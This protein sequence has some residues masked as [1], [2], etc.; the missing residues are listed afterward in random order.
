MG[1]S[2]IVLYILAG[3]IGVI[4]SFEWGFNVR[5]IISA[6]VVGI[7]YCIISVICLKF[8]Q[9]VMGNMD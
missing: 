6:L 2:L 9:W 8:T 4:F 3:V 1:L 5:E 7:G